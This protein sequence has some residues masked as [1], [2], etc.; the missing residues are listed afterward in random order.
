[1]RQNTFQSSNVNV[2]WV[3]MKATQINMIFSRKE[4]CRGAG[5][6]S[7]HVINA[8][9][10]IGRLDQAIPQVLFIKRCG[11]GPSIKYAQSNLMFPSSPSLH[12][13]FEST[14]FMD[15]P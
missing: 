5:A 10:R 12:L 13:I 4:V 1:M 2:A 11:K 9:I 7:D 6:D 3:H 14:Y 15:G 8:T